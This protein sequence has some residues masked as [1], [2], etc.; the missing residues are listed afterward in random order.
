MA[1]N[2][3]QE[4]VYDAMRSSYTNPL[5]EVRK[6]MRDRSCSAS[7]AQLVILSGLVTALSG[8]GQPVPLR[9]ALSED[10]CQKRRHRR[11]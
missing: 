9:I 11:E 5:D 6:T 1:K 4:M 8:V 10:R 3:V 7:D 2:K